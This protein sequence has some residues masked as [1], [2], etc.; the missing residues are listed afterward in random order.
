VDAAVLSTWNGDPSIVGGIASLAFIG[1][2]AVARDRRDGRTVSRRAVAAYVG[3]LVTLVFALASPLDALS[4]RVFLSAHMVQHL[5]LLLAVPVLLLAGLPTSVLTSVGDVLRG[6]WWSRRLGHPFPVFLIALGAMWIW[7]APQLYEAALHAEAIHAAEHL[8]FLAT[9]VLLWW[10]VVRG[11]TCPWR[12][13]DPLL[14]VYLFGAAVGSS[15]LAAL[16]TFSPG[17]LYSTY[18]DPSAYA[19]IRDA[20]GLT[21]E[22]DQQVG[23]LLMWVAGGLWYFGAAVAVFVRWFSAPGGDEAAGP[24][25]D[26]DRSG[27][28]T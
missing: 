12:L 14:I 3:A 26:L 11:S 23:G 24:D 13:P 18:A 27:V 16:V 4:D 20:L 15:M 2:I 8:S 21:P 5:C 9:A 22:V 19:T 7:H 6:T 1:V 28:K 17:V 10:P 25:V